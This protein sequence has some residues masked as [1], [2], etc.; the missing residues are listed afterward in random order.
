[1]G[2]VIDVLKGMK[3]GDVKRL[4]NEYIHIDRG[5]R[6]NI[7]NTP[8]GKTRIKQKCKPLLQNP[9]LSLNPRQTYKK[10]LAIM[11]FDKILNDLGVE[12][13]N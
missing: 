4:T 8:Q 10:P 11:K 6:R 1:M 2:K 13:L 7:Q 3:V 12:S 9:N 5:E